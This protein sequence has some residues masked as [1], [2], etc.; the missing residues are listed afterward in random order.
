MRELFVLLQVFLGLIFT[1]MCYLLG[2]YTLQIYIT[3]LWYRHK[4]Y[5][6]VM[7]HP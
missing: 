6:L 1:S 4:M 3:N 2:I 7:K 5:D